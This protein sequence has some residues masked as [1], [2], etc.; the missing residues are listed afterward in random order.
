MVIALKNKKYNTLGNNRGVTLIEI[1]VVVAIMGVIASIVIPSYTDYTR[2]TKITEAVNMLPS[3]Q[4]ELELEYLIKGSYR[5]SICSE[6]SKQAQYFIF[7]CELTDAGYLISAVGRSDQ[8][9][10]GY[11][12]TL[13]QDGNKATEI[14]GNRIEGCWKSS[15]GA[16]C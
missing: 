12:Y 11:R 5:L 2:R 10:A 1:L 6:K 16:I 7:S 9:M 4:L 13:N 3:I 15:K 8:D 14:A